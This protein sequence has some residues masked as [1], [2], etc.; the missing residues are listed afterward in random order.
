MPE[1]LRAFESF[2][3]QLLKN[4]TFGDIFKNIITELK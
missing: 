2:N 1:L 3:A 4:K